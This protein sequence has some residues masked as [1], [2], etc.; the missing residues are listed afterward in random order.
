[1]RPAFHQRIQRRF[2]GGI[3]APKRA[4]F[5]RCAGGGEDGARRIG[6]QQQRF[7]GANEARIGGHIH[8]QHFVHFLRVN[9]R[10]GGERPQHTGIADH[11]V[12]LAPT[13][14]NAGPQAVKRIAIG[15]V[16][17]HAGRFATGFFDEVV[18]F[19]QRALCAPEHQHM[20]ALGRQ[21][22]GHGPAKTARRA[23][24]QRQFAVKAHISLVPPE[25]RVGAVFRR[26]AGRSSRSGNRR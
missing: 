7:H 9:M 21:C 23:G 14:G 4:A 6:L 10:D 16:H 2:A 3:S 12:E 26:L 11:Q 20:R 17:R 1:M 22:F 13:L 8:G 25:A 24:D 5:L 15:D 19:F 18:K